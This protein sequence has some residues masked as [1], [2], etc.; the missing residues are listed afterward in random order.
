LP[1]RDNEAHFRDILESIDLVESFLTDVDSHW[2][3]SPDVAA[4]VVEG[5]PTMLELIGTC[6]AKIH[7]IRHVD[8][9]ISRA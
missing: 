9:R 4:P 8:L 5:L 7:R 6:E 3:R 2:H 1:F